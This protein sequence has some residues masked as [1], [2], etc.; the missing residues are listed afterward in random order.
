MVG[1]GILWVCLLKGTSVAQCTFW[2]YPNPE[3]IS[4]DALFYDPRKSYIYNP[5]KIWEYNPFHIC[6]TDLLYH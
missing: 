2:E 4:L 6:G 1:A 5:G 3:S